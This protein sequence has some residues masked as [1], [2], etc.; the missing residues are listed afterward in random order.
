MTGR[1]VVE[2]ANGLAVVVTTVV[3]VALWMLWYN[4]GNTSS[5]DVSKLSRI[6][7]T[8]PAKARNCT[9]TVR[10]RR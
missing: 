2:K 4:S 10:I 5:S 7:F 8:Q 1:F 3:I 6:I 9:V